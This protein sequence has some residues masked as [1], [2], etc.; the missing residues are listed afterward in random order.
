[1]TSRRSVLRLK[2]AFDGALGQHLPGAD[3][4]VKAF[5]RYSA[6][7]AVVEVAAGQPPRARRD[8]HRARLGQALQAGGE[9]GGFADHTALLRLAR[10]GQIADD[11]ET[12]GDADADLQAN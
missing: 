1:M 2:P 3:R 8:H 10:S 7:L 5:E 9:I 11:D 6:K 4:L 12:G